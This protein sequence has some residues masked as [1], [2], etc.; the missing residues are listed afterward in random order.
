MN[1]ILE[2][3]YEVYMP[4]AH[5]VVYLLKEKKFRETI[6]GVNFIFQGANW[7]SSNILSLPQV[8]YTILWITRDKL[9]TVRYTEV[10]Y[11]EIIYVRL[12]SQEQN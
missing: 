2:S 1:R 7:P 11:N 6:I 4:Y 8:L 10:G 12:I 3:E 9:Y 5:V